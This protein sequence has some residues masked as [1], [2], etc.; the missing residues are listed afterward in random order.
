MRKRNCLFSCAL[1][2]SLTFGQGIRGEVYIVT[3]SSA[4]IPLPLVELSVY[5]LP[6]AMKK[7]NA[8]TEFYGKYNKYIDSSRVA[9]YNRL[10]PVAD[11]IKKL[12]DI[13]H[14]RINEVIDS[15]GF[16]PDRVASSIKW[17]AATTA[18]NAIDAVRDIINTFMDEV[19]KRGRLKKV[20]P[21]Y[22]LSSLPMAMGATK[23]NAHGEYS[24]RLK[25]RGEYLIVAHSF[26]KTYQTIEEYL[27][28]VKV[29]YNGST[30][31]IDLNNDNLFE[32]KCN[33]CLN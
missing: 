8:A 15:I 17:N 12:S 23:T 31:V 3:S 1:F 19:K 24:L 22:Y 10:A 2:F 14:K 27:W 28:M 20:A 6:E 4:V 30:I 25:K 26:R 32:T 18:A 21:E 13:A 5:S 33:T 11:S 7:I 16:D 9:D 29:K